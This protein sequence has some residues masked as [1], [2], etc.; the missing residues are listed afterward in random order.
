MGCTFKSS[1]YLTF[2]AHKSKVQRE[3]NWCTVSENESSGSCIPQ[4]EML[5]DDEDLDNLSEETSETNSQNLGNLLE[6]NLAA[7]FLNMQTVLH[8]PEKSV[9]EVSQQLCQYYHCMLWQRWMSC[10]RQKKSIICFAQVSTGNGNR[11]CSG[12][13]HL[14][15][16]I[17]SFIADASEIKQARHW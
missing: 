1:V 16:C 9:Q 2:N 5:P 6:H 8:I 15:C 13:R 7:L 11:I 17:C 3:R 12:E 14:N 10:N 4:E